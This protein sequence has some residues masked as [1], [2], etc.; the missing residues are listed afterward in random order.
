MTAADDRKVIMTVLVDLNS[1][2][3]IKAEAARWKETEKMF[4]QQI[5][6]KVDN[7]HALLRKGDTTGGIDTH[8][9]NQ[10]IIEI[11]H[12]YQDYGVAFSTARSLEMFGIW[13]EQWDEPEMS[14]QS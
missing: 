8:E 14:Q 6:E 10:A 11:A 1:V 12:L 4:E 7:L 5:P 9:L 13:R 3:S 2:D